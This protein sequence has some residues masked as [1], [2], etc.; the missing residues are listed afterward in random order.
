METVRRTEDPPATLVP[1][2]ELRHTRHNAHHAPRSPMTF[3]ELQAAIDAWMAQFEAGYWPPLANVA[4]LAEEVGELAREVNHAHG[5]K[6]KR[7]DEAD[8][9]IAEELGD[10]LF[11]VAT[12]ANSLDIDLEEVVEANLAKVTKRYTA[13]WAKK[14]PPL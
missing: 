13:R 2:I 14:A 3:R 4:R 6:T 11:K 8:G 7:A 1:R 10:I 5:P 9:S 12:I